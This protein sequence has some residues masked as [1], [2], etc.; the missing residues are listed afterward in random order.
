MESREPGDLSVILAAVRDGEAGAEERLFERVYQELHRIAHRE[1]RREHS[2][3]TLMQTTALVNETWLRLAGNSPGDWRDRRY[4]FGAASRAM[5][6]VLVDTARKRKAAR[7]AGD[8]QRITLQSNMPGQE[9][10]YEILALHE[11]L[12]GLA[13][14]RQRA[15]DVVELRFFGGL[16]VEETARQL[17][18][19]PRSVDSDWNFARRWL[20]RTMTE[21]P[22]SVPPA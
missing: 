13:V 20:E 4:F 17:E 5:R 19:S 16:T 6:R 2:R 14:I 18:V 9:P 8:A 12:D 15:A 10:S 3:P 11:A 22:D 1:M 7:R 21:R